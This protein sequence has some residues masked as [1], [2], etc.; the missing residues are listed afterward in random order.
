MSS[1]FN[2]RRYRIVAVEEFAAGCAEAIPGLERSRGQSWANDHNIQDNSNCAQSAER[3]AFSAEFTAGCAAAVASRRAWQESWDQEK[4]REWARASYVY[5]A[6]E[7]GRHGHETDQPAAFV[8]GCKLEISMK[9]PA[10]ASAEG[11]TPLPKVLGGQPRSGSP[12]NRSA[13]GE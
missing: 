6:E 8:T 12:Q 13:T 9:K 3:T 1:R 11:A 7:S 5:N 2:D 4:G 10:D